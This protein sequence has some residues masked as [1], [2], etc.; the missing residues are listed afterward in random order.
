[1]LARRVCDAAVLRAAR[2]RD[3]SIV[4]IDVDADPALEAGLR[5]ARPGAFCRRSGDGVELCHYRL[6]RARVEAALAGAGERSD[7][8][9]VP[10]ENP[11]KFNMIRAARG[12]VP[13]PLCF[14]AAVTGDERASDPQLFHHRPH[15]PRQIDAGRPLHPALRR[16]RRPRDGRAGAR[17]DGPRARARDHDQGADRGAHVHGARRRRS[18]TST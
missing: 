17:L 12:T 18:T 14:G 11:L 6:D 16:P 4:V 7:R 1:M 15:R 10:G 5:R 13:V 2:R 8:G 9:R 3:A